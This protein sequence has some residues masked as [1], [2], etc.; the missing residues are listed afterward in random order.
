MVLLI[1]VP[2][3]MFYFY[4]TL[5]QNASYF[6]LILQLLSWFRAERDLFKRQY[7]YRVEASELLLESNLSE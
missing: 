3:N 7:W 6:K 4:Q 5:R 2:G 1:V